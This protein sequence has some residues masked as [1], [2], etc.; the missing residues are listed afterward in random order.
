MST[1]LEQSYND[2]L[3][4]LPVNQAIF[5]VISALRKHI[6]FDFALGFKVDRGQM[7]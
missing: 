5:L 1:I 7:E 3:M 4:D 2:L 6:R